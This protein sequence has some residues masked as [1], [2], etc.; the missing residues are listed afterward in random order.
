MKLVTLG[1][2]APASEYDFRRLVSD[3]FPPTE[4]APDYPLLLLELAQLQTPTTDQYGDLVSQALIQT[5]KASSLATA[6]R[7]LIEAG[8]AGEDGEI[9]ELRKAVEEAVNDL[10][11]VARSRQVS[12]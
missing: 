2:P 7:E 3:I 1:N 6:I 11:P 5:E 12:G 10:L 4:P 8:Q 9:L